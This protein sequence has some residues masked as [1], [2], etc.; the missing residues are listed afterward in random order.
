MPFEVSRVSLYVTIAGLV[1]ALI[2]NIALGAWNLSEL[3][4]RVG[5]MELKQTSMVVQEEENRISNEKTLIEIG[6][7]GAQID[8]VSRLLDRVLD[9]NDTH[10]K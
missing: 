4:Y 9:Q 3:F 1:G 10:K 7:V 5:A 6:K 2:I 8:G